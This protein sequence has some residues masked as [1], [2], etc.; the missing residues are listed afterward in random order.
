MILPFFD[1]LPTSTWTFFTLNVDQNWHYLTT[2]PPYFVHVVFEWPLMQM[3]TDFP[4]SFYGARICIRKDK[5]ILCV[6]NHSLSCT[7]PRHVKLLEDIIQKEMANKIISPYFSKLVP[8]CQ[9][10]VFKTSEQ[11]EMQVVYS[12]LLKV[13][14]DME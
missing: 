12:R 14:N 13:Q 1:H 6:N 8:S 9:S 5:L 7:C 11:F 3:N 10:D 4:R 2:Y